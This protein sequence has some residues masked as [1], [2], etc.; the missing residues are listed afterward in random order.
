MV[1]DKF[2][3]QLDGDPNQSLFIGTGHPDKGNVH[4]EV[5]MAEAVKNSQKDGPF[6]DAVAKSLL[7]SIYSEWDELF[8]HRFAAEVGAKAEDVS[9]DLMGDLRWVRHWI[10]HNK[11][12]IDNNCSKYPPAKPGALMVS[13]SKAP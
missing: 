7:V 12:R 1:A 10:V 4:S 8:R 13:A 11:Y 3:S 9:C 6:S 2:R 5:Q